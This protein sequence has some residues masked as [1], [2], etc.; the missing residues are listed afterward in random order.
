M[1]TYVRKCQ[2]LVCTTT[3]E[4]LHDNSSF[5]LMCTKT[6]YVFNLS[7]KSPKCFCTF[8]SSVEYKRLNYVRNF[9]LKISRLLLLFFCF[10]ICMLKIWLSEQTTTC[11]PR[12]F[13]TCVINVIRLFWTNICTMFNYSKYN[14]IFHGLWT[15]FFHR[16]FVVII[17]K[18]RLN[19]T[20]SNMRVSVSL[21][22]SI[23]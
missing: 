2:K 14:S 15:S 12:L 10:L 21:G 7:S 3:D 17:I 11:V 5:D 4:K 22:L 16:C 18:T 1:C 9:P 8:Y 19:I 23:K 13:F 6:P 20:L